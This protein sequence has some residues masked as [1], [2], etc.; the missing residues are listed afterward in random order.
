MN[1]EVKREI[2]W[3]Q[4]IERITLPLRRILDKSTGT[5]FIIRNSLFDIRYSEHEPQNIEQGMMNTEAK[6]EI[7]LLLLRSSTVGSILV[8]TGIA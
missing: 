3:L 1:Y 8:P 2:V 5:Y 7:V 6:S 4:T